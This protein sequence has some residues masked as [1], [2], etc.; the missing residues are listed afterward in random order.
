MF[1]KAYGKMRDE[2]QMTDTNGTLALCLKN[3]S[4]MLW[5]HWTA[6]LNLVLGELYSVEICSASFFAE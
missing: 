3:L 4:E 5:A 1:I 2:I 6:F